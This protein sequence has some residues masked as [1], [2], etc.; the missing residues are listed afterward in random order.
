MSFPL[1]TDTQHL[2][3]ETRQYELFNRPLGQGVVRRRL[4][5]GI[6]VCVMWTVAL[7]VIGVNPLW[8]LGPA[9]Y[10]VPPFAVVYLGTR[11][12]EDGR[13]VAMRW[14]DAV[15]A[16]TPRRRMPVRNPLL[17][18]AE[19]RAETVLRVEGSTTELHPHSGPSGAVT[20]L[21]GR[22]AQRNRT[23]N[24]ISHDVG[25]GV[26]SGVRY[27]VRH[28]V[29]GETSDEENTADTADV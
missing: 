14:Y 18:S 23:R 28:G 4:Y 7:L 9:L 17:A 29:K 6:A 15:L 25:H 11:V 22:T 8:R 12:G 19:D 3:L 16:R 21:V 24:R 13:M 26:R 2:Q 10:I 1:P 5:L 20:R 27:G